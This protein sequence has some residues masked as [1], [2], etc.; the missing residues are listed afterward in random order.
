[1]IY[2]KNNSKEGYF[3]LY[4]LGLKLKKSD[5]IKYSNFNWVYLD[6]DCEYK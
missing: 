3:E 2:Q 6:C 4:K 1:M 5:R